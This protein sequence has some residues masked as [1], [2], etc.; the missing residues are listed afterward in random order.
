MTLS[1]GIR[2]EAVFKGTRYS[3]KKCA[4][5]VHDPWNRMERNRK[6]IT[7]FA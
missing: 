4:H 6:S 2:D 7:G 1:R 3:W 5:C